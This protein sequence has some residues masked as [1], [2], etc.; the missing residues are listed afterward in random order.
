MFVRLLEAPGVIRCL[1]GTAMWSIALE[2]LEGQAVAIQVGA[3]VGRV[4]G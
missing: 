4:A 2:R 1:M 3:P